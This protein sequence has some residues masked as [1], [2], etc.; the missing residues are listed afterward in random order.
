MDA[1]AVH[2]SNLSFA[3]PEPKPSTSLYEQRRIVGG[4]DP[5]KQVNGRRQDAHVPLSIA[6]PVQRLNMARP[7]SACRL[8]RS[9]NSSG[10]TSRSR[11]EFATG[12]NL[13]E[14]IKEDLIAERIAVEFYSAIIRWL[15]D[16]DLTTRKVMQEILAIEAQHAED[17]KVFSKVSKL[18]LN[19]TFCLEYSFAGGSPKR[20]SL[21][22]FGCFQEACPWISAL[23]FAIAMSNQRMPSAC[24]CPLHRELR[25]PAARGVTHTAKSRRPLVPVGATPSPG[26]RAK[27]AVSLD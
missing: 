17:M 19:R 2:K 13:R 26:E 14:M 23:W 20:A 3:F 18:I 5:D 7:M 1:G 11:S 12:R 24:S 9:A 25:Q 21:V 15:G 4:F 27:G 22:D 8:L 6:A 10:L 16:S